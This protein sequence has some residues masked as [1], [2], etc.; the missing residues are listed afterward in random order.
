MNEICRW[1]LLLII[2]EGT[3]QDK[4][5]ATQIRFDLMQVNSECMLMHADSHVTVELTVMRR[6][7]LQ[8]QVLDCSFAFLLETRTGPTYIQS[9]CTC[10]TVT[11]KMQGDAQKHVPQH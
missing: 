10:S 2:T 4:E 6:W 7:F 5:M 3:R 8:S 9:A 1:I 11:N